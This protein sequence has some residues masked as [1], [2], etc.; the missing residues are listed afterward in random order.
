ML[1]ILYIKYAKKQIA[2]HKPFKIQKYACTRRKDISRPY[3]RA[4]VVKQ[5]AEV[6]EAFIEHGTTF[7]AGRKML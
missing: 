5:V 6:M 7:F 1:D 3:D 4:K 2:G